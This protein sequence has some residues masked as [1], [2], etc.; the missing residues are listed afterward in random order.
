MVDW[1]RARMNEAI[2]NLFVQNPRVPYT[3]DGIEL[4]K[5]AVFSV[6]DTL[7]RRGGVSPDFPIVVEAPAPSDVSAEDRAERVL[8]DVTFDF[9][10]VGAIHKVRVQGTISL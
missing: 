7:R 10:F 3:T 6:I 2:L 4:V 8:P 5:N 9:V 1:L